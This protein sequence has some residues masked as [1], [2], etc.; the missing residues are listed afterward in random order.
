MQKML[1]EYFDKKRFY[2]YI[3]N[4]VIFI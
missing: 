2:I 1:F 4:A 3:D